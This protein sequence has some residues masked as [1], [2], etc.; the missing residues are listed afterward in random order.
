MSNGWKES[1]SAWIAAQ[2]EELFEKIER[3]FPHCLGCK[4][5]IGTPGD[6]NDRERDATLIERH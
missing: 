4:P 1:A 5:T 3:A 2:G 6:D